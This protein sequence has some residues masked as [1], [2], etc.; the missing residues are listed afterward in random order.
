LKI[1]LYGIALYILLIPQAYTQN[2]KPVI[3]LILPVE[4]SELSYISNRISKSKNFEVNTYINKKPDKENRGN[5]LVIVSDRLLPLLADENYNAKFA[6][7]VNSVNFKNSH[8]K[9]S[10]AIFSDQP[11]NRQLA[12]LSKIINKKI[13]VGIP[14]ENT[15]Y[16]ILIENEIKKFSEFSFQVVKIENN[17]LRSINQVIQSSDVILATAERAI[18][19]SQ[20]I[21]PILLSSYRHHTPVIGPN[22]GFVTAGSLAS[23]ASNS[24]QY[25]S[26]LTEMI[27]EYLVSNKIPTARYPK[28]YIV[29]INY[30]VAESLG[31]EIPKN[32]QITDQEEG[33]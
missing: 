13:T 7:Y 20:N 27:N 18:Y 14:Y 9:N 2:S 21:R 1:L 15:N 26:E 22:E 3:D 24:D 10:S 16:K 29:K 31:I 28:G 4:N 8:Y 5:I 33:D 30:N 32:I 11:L 19:N 6:L 25:V 17:K 12:L 23:A